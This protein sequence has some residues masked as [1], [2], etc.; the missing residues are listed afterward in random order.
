MAKQKPGLHK[1][2]QLIFEGVPIP[3]DDSGAESDS[4]PAPE[5]RSHLPP[6]PPAASVR[7]LET[8]EP[9]VPTQPL[10]ESAFAS[11]EE[12]EAEKIVK[13]E[14]RTRWHKIKDRL[15]GAEES[16]SGS[17]QKVM[18][19]LVPIL[20][21]VL[22]V[23]LVR[24]LQTAPSRRSKGPVGVASSGPSEASGNEIEWE[25]P[26]PYPTTIRDPM[27][28]GTT[29]VEQTRVSQIIV[30]GIVLSEDGATAVIGTK[31]VR[32][33]DEIDGVVIV[34]INQD[35]VD[36]EKD[37]EKWTQEVER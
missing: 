3:K 22:I 21:T 34:K 5:D 31:I 18:V 16:I 30:R 1:R 20:L 7:V 11:P 19:L 2:I 32:E 8:R 35:S 12:P 15:F 28:F 29:A 36:F 13:P 26:E 6:E 4:A 10:S 24:Y 33:G 27:A 23:L 9:Y 17:R 14:V 37:G 25:I